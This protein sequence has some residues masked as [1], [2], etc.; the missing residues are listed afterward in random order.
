MNIKNDIVYDNI[1]RV[2]IGLDP[3]KVYFT[4]TLNYLL[5]TMLKFSVKVQHNMKQ[6]TY[7]IIILKLE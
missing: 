4:I 1:R 2:D 3:T 5:D 6:D 7:C